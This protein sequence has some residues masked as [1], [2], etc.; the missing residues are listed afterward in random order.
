[1]TCI[2]F[3]KQIMPFINKELDDDELDDFLAHLKT[4]PECMEELEVYYT[5]ITSMKQLDEDKDLSSDYRKDLFHLLEKTEEHINSKKLRQG[6]KRVYLVI[7]IGIIAVTSTYRFGEYVVEDV[8]HKASVSDFMPDNVNLIDSNDVP[9]V[10]KEQLPSIYMYLRETNRE[11]ALSMAEYYGDI[12]WD[13]M[14]IQKEFGQTN[15]PP[16]WT[17]LNY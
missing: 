4:C 17:I 9:L 8:I 12:I 3:E 14:I 13:N 2:D 11:G 1:M 16:S 15:K 6:L 7:I 10:F 5:L